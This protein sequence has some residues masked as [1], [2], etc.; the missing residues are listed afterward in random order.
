[1]TVVNYMEDFQN[2]LRP[3][4]SEGIRSIKSI[5]NLIISVDPNDMAHEYSDIRRAIEKAKQH[6]DSAG[7][8]ANAKLEEVNRKLEQ[9]VVEKTRLDRAEDAKKSEHANLTRER[10]ANVEKLVTSKQQLRDAWKHVKSCDEALESAHQKKKEADRNM[11]IG[12]ALL[13]IPVFGTI[14]G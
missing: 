12:A 3:S 11:A 14:A 8:A 4:L 6:L 2:A 7:N 13:L 1:M 5:A 10:V 9:L